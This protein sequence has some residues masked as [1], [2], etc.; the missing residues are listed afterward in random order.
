MN[1]EI[2]R[3]LLVVYLVA[4]YVM[5]ILYLRRRRLSFGEY[6]FWGLFALLVPVVG[7]FLVIFSQPGRGSRRQRRASRR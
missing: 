3:S 5:A 7:P 1:A 4:A 6:T 2:L